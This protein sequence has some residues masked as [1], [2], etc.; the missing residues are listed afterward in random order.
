MKEKIESLIEKWEKRKESYRDWDSYDE[1]NNWVM[2][3]I[4]M[5]IRDL[6]LLTKEEENVEKVECECWSRNCDIC[7]PKF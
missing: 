1:W 2:L 3:W 7:S 5:C 6:E 4:W